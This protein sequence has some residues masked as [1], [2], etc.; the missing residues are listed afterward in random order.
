MGTFIEELGR[1]DY[2]ALKTH[3]DDANNEVD[4]FDPNFNEVVLKAFL[5]QIGQSAIAIYTH[6]Q[7]CVQNKNMPV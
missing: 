7:K 2:Q 1:K 6:Q 5:W 3:E 4:F